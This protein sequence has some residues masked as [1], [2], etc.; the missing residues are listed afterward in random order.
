MDMIK[1]FIE[2]IINV[3]LNNPKLLLETSILI[4]LCIIL[5]IYYPKFRGFMGEFWVK[6]ELGKLPKDKYIVLNDIMI[7]D[8][9]GTHQIDHLIVSSFGIFVIE[10]KN[11]YGL[12][13]GKEYDNKWC[14]YLGKTKN[15]FLNPIHQNYGHIKSLSNLLKLDDKYF[16][17]IVCFSNQA[18]IDVKCSSIVT[19]V[20][21]LKAE[22][23]KYR[24]LNL[25]CNINELAKIIISNNIVDKKMRKQH[26]KDIQVKVNYNKQ[27]EKNMICPKCGNQLVEK[28]GRY[29]KFIGCSNYPKCKYIK[30]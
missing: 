8:E 17:S 5:K 11:Y 1:S 28:N 18:K 4:V 7:K 13:K 26:I 15:Y 29:G 6:L 2:G 22:I 16:I 12:I 23:L 9:R 24:D 27:L 19:Q 25:E 3:Y 14:Q 10:M 20:D 30:K 21:F